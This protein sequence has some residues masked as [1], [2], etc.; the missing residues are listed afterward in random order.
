MDKVLEYGKKILEDNPEIAQRRIFF[1]FN[2]ENK[3]ED[4]FMIY[5]L[6][7]YEIKIVERKSESGFEMGWHQD[8]IS[9][10]RNSKKHC[11]K[12]NKNELKPYCISNPPKYTMLLYYSTIGEDFEGGEFC[13]VDRKI[14]PTKGMGILFDSREIHKVNRIKK[15]EKKVK[16]IKFY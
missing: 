14:R 10:H 4:L 2:L 16:I 5:G 7:K 13:F 11:E 12:Y 3:I 1:Q 8:D 9:F 15:G 6:D